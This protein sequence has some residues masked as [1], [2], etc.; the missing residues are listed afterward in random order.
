MLSRVAESVYWMARYV[1]RA[2]NIARFVD[3]NLRFNLDETLTGRDQWEPLVQITGDEKEYEK[4]YG[5][6]S[7]DQVVRFL[8]FDRDYSN[9]VISALKMARENARTIRETIPSEAWEQLNAFYHF[10][11]DTQLSTDIEEELSNYLAQLK[12]HA[13]LYCGILETTMSR[14]EGWHFANLGKM[15]ERADKTSRLLDVKYFRL[16]PNVNDVNTTL[17]DLQ[18]SA[19]LRSVSGFEMYRKRFHAITVTKVL[20]FL[21]RDVEFPRS[22]LFCLN[23]ACRSM[24]AIAAM[25]ECSPQQSETA[26]LYQLRESLLGLTA[27]NIID[28]GLHEFVDN[29]QRRVNEVDAAIQTK[30]F[31]HDIASSPVAASPLTP[32]SPT[33]SQS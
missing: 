6:F 27:R 21:T 1:E 2:D 8:I 11:R 23:D 14:N 19:L 28:N 18:W 15:L 13:L 12:S 24:S 9:S 7:R 22:I 29:F 4:R 30:Y 25:D 26:T 33:Q 20:E 17:D 31:A 10:V 32:M 3:V 16:M 5:E